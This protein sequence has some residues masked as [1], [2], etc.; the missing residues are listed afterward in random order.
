MQ[1]Q[2]TKFQEQLLQMQQRQQQHQENT[3]QKRPES[4]VDQHLGS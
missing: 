2:Q 4:S 1:A 3:V